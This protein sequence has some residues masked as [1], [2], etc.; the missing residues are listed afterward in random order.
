VNGDAVQ[1]LA[2]AAGF[3]GGPR[4]ALFDGK[5]LFATPTRLVNDFFA[6]PG[7]D[8]ITLRNGAFV[9]VGDISGDGLADLAFGGGPGGAPRVFALSGQ[10]VTGAGVQSAYS[11]PV[12]NFFV[13]NNS[14][15]RGGVR[16]AVTDA[17]ADGRADLA[18]GSGEGL[19]GRVRVYLGKNFATPAEPTTFQD[20]S[21]F[22][23]TALAAGVFV[24]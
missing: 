15:D 12:A 7:D 8:A 22:G 23:G 17:D 18:A 2:V 4:V 19:P 10:L 14:S 20:L 5:T 1:D 21:V 16:V 6:F 24:G 9:S 3:L 11:S 13:A